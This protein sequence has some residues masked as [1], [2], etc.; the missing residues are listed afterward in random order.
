[1]MKRILELIASLLKTQASK[2]TMT[3]L[4]DRI[5]FTEHSTIG[6]LSID[7][8]FECYILEDYDRLSKGENKVYGKTAIPRGTYEI[9]LSYSPRFKKKLPLLTNVP[10]FTGIRIHAGNTAKDTEGCLLPGRT[11][12]ENFV[13]QSKRAFNSLIKKLE[14]AEREGKRIIIQVEPI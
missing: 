12:S 9:K 8:E 11:R 5:W 2:P 10:G 6:E 7:G 13:G 14:S 3:L 1:M 4:L